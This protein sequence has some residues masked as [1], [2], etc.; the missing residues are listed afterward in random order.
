MAKVVRYHFDKQML[1]KMT[2]TGGLII[3]MCHK[4]T[5]GNTSLAEW[6]DWYSWNE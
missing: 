4:I 3:I 2:H 1:Q 6:D 5:I